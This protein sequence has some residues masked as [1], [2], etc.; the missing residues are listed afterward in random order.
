MSRPAA[1]PARPVDP[2]VLRPLPIAWNPKPSGSARSGVERLAD[3]RV[4]CWIEHDTLRG[5]TPQMLVWWF[6]HL[7]GEME[8]EGVRAQ[9]YRFWHPLDHVQVRYARRLRDGSVGPGAVLHITEMLG[10]RPEYLV[11]VKSHIVRL[12]LGGF[13]HRPR[14]HGLPLAAMDY[15]FEA[16]PGGTRYRNS[17]TVGLAHTWAR[18]L[19]ALLRRYAFDD[20]RGQAWI[21]HNIEEVG[22]FERFLPALIAAEAPHVL[23]PSP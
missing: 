9:R 13:G 17:L 23:A 18:P 7:E 19:N 10:A 3:G 12:D 11:D 4:H 16:V 20:E 1:L 2:R 14:L 5:V 15:S 8:H 21:R 22:Q 6:Q